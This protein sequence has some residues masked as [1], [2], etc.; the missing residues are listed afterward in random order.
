MTASR[1][2]V[3][4]A[5]GYARVSTADQY[6]EGVS[7]GAQAERITHYCT[8]HGTPLTH[9][10]IDGGVSGGTPLSERPEGAKMLDAIGRR[11]VA[12]VV[13]LKLDRLFRSTIDC[14][15]TIKRWDK[16]RVA[17]HL[18]DFNGAQLDTRS[19]MGR[20]MLTM[21]A[22][23]A[24]ME[25]SLIGE[26]TSSA[27]QHMKR[28]GVRLG[29]VPFGFTT[30]TPGG[31]LVPNADELVAVRQILALRG[32]S[33]AH[34]SYRSIARQLTQAGH[35]TRHGGAWKP[36]TVRKIAERRDLYRAI[37]AI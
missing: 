9:V 25:R 16:Q 36:E 8:I 23:F 10:Y 13:S 34:A 2:G 7:I 19:A 4:V 18:I 1:S 35:R 27:L 12:A 29:G 37:P 11:E 22:A 20:L 32:P 33:D 15:E 31:A 24:E 17:L 14:L 30:E 6:R 3:A 28:Q 5:A 26:R 21:G